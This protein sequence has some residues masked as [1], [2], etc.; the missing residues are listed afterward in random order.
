MKRA[1]LNFWDFSV[2]SVLLI[3][4]FSQVGLAILLAVIAFLLY[5]I[6]R[7]QF[8][9]VNNATT[10]SSLRIP[11]SMK[12]IELLQKQLAEAEAEEAEAFKE[13]R[14][15]ET[16]WYEKQWL[17]AM[18]KSQRLAEEL[19]WRKNLGEGATIKSDFTTGS[20]SI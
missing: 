11:A 9:T 4:G 13:F 14:R 6:V 7:M 12:P 20:L 18:Q 15:W 10:S 19:S 8:G 2:A 3:L 1:R 16:P 5:M 17:E